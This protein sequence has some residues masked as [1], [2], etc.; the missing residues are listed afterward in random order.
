MSGMVESV[1]RHSRGSYHGSRLRYSSFAGLANLGVYSS[2]RPKT[3]CKA[4]LLWKEMMGFAELY[5]YYESLQ[6]GHLA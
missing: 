3:V 1:L 2:G 4:W 6:P 5:P